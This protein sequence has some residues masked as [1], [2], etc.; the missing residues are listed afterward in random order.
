[1]KTNEAARIFESD[2]LE[3]VSRAHPVLNTAVGVFL[4]GFCASRVNFAALG[5]FAAA[6]TVAAVVF[7]WTLI[8]YAMHRFV[9]HWTP[10]NALAARV[11]Y[12]VHAYHHDHPN[13]SSRNMFPLAMSLPFALLVWLA[14][15][16]LM[17]REFSLLAFAVL[18]LMFTIYDLVH[19]LH[20]MPTKFMPELRRRHMLHHFRDHDANFGV[21]SSLWDR[22]F[23]TRG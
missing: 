23:R 1:M 5:L 10:K 7:G 16:T 20:H 13:E 17:P 14:M 19:Y 2:L 3:A 15:W 11:M 21:T 6:A 9:F 22:V 18:V 8:E 12:L 4:A